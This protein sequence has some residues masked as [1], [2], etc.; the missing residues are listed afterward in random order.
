M[1]NI[2]FDDANENWGLFLATY[3]NG[4]RRA[5]SDTTRSGYQ[6]YKVYLDAKGNNIITGAQ[7]GFTALKT[8]EVF[9]VI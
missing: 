4:V 9:E 2:G 3:P 1:A 8:L 5:Y 6:G 7:D